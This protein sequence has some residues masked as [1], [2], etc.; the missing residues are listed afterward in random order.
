MEEVSYS[1][2]IMINRFNNFDKY[3]KTRTTKK[4]VI[5]SQ[6]TPMRML[7][8]LRLCLNPRATSYLFLVETSISIFTS[9]RIFIPLWFQ[10]LKSCQEKSIDLLQLKM[11]KSMTVLKWDLTHAFISPSTS[12]ETTQNMERLLN[13]QITSSNTPESRK[14]ADSSTPKSRRSTSTGVLSIKLVSQ[15]EISQSILMP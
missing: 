10:D 7:E 2:L 13:I 14:F 9:Q 1:W 6:I 3:R 8:S 15:R 4:R 5:T 11:E 12:W